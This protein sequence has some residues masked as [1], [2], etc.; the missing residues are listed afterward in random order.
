MARPGLT[1]HRKFKRLAR[2]LGSPMLARGA[3]ELLWDSC[4]EAGEEYVGT[5]E[6]IE[7]T[8]GWGGVPGVLTSALSGAG[9]PEG[10]GFIEPLEG[11]PVR[12]KVHDLWHHAPDYVAKRRRRE[13][14]RL[15]KVAPTVPAPNGGQCPPSSDWPDEV[16][17]TPSPPHSP[18]P[19]PSPGVEESAEAVTG[20]APAGSRARAEISL[21]ADDDSPIVLTFPVVGSKDRPEWRLRRR[22]V[23]EWQ[24]AYPNLE[25]MDECRRALAW[26]KANLGRR[27]TE[28][29][30]AKFLNGWLSRT[31]DRRVSPRLEASAGPVSAQERTKAENYRRAIGRCPHPE[32]CDGWATCVGRIVGEWRDDERAAMTP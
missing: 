17:R 20:S 25:V 10:F 15:A 31:V 26:V 24:E 22:Q 29:G 4:Y 9:A 12:Y 11:E 7:A 2:A 1:G 8:V 16:G 19:A 23:E 14:E 3:L 6:D 13:L 28:K 32:R 5:A 27:K 18:S 21:R 30:M